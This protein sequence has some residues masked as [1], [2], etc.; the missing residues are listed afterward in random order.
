[1]K[2]IKDLR[3]WIDSYDELDK[4]TQ[5]LSLAAEFIKEGLVDEDELDQLYAKA[6]EKVQALESRGRLTSGCIKNQLRS[7]RNRKSGLGLDADAH[8]PALGRIKRI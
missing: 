4:I 5:E 3:N 7:R 8:V 2:K 1:M 6:T